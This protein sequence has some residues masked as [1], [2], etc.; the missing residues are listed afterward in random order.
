MYN[1]FYYMVGFNVQ[2]QNLVELHNMIMKII[3]KYG[4]IP[5]LTFGNL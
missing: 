3:F 4:T 5:D 2:A 1:N